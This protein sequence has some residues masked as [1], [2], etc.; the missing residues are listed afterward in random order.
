[1]N[2]LEL[3]ERL[4]ERSRKL[5]A[6]EAEACVM[7]SASVEIEI[8]N[9]RAETVNYKNQ[10]G[11][12]LRALKDGRMG[13]A[14]S[15]NLD[16]SSAD[17]IIRKL[18][19]NTAKHSLDEHNVLPDPVPEAS[20]DHS[21]ERYDEK[22][23]TIPVK[24]KIEKAIAIDTAARSA[25]PRIVQ[26]GW[27]QYGDSAD[28]YAIVSSKGIMYESRR[29][30]I[31]GYI[32]AVAMET[33]PGGQSDPTGAQ[34]GTGIEVKSY[35]D[36]LDPENP[37]KKAARTAL[38]M[39]GATDGET[40]EVEAVFPP[41]SGYSFIDLIADMVSADLV[42][43]KKSIF[44]GRLRE[45][46][47]SEKVTI[48]DDGRLKGG[49]ASAALDGEG[50][51]TGTKEIIAGGRLTQLLYDS[52]TAHKGGTEP[53]GNAER[54]S[55]SSRPMIA[56]T[57][58]YLRPGNA[59]R[60]K[61]IGSV[62]NGLY[63]TEV[64]GLHASVDPITGNFSIPCKGL[65]I[66]HGEL[67]RPVSNITISGNMFDFLKSIDGIADDLTWEVRGNVIGVPTYRVSGIKISGK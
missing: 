53:T 50:L 65:M 56:P 5:G 31:Y 62:G 51:P 44:T 47:A 17:D 54:P 23:K 37:G 57:N 32:V 67:S 55:Y 2:R 8:L 63:I 41:E 60:D 13:F 4:V 43:K 10:R 1:M 25:D 34:T 49:L 38:R 16:L 59:S 15:N 6:D 52:Y 24:K 22:L 18:I 35:F 40:G 21:L 3:A 19:T 64:S 20:D 61:L 66:E 29:S 27:L 36:D 33:T 42:Q 30:E 7:E 28:E 14:S 46:V 58:F 45:S 48:I 39:L 11:F 12:G 26:I 9:S